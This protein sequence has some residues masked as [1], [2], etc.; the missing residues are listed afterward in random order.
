MTKNPPGPCKVCGRK[1]D[2]HLLEKDCKCDTLCFGLHANCGGDEIEVEG[3]YRV[4]DKRHPKKVWYCTRWGN[5]LI[6]D[7]M[8]WIKGPWRHKEKACR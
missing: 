8:Q 5:T 2:P 7:P 4:R 6:E 1:Y 3:F